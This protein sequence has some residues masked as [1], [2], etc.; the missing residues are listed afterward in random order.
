MYN[1]DQKARIFLSS[2]YNLG[3]VTHM[4][5]AHPFLCTDRILQ[6]LGFWETRYLVAGKKINGGI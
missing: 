2:V 6:R 4:T 3:I 1:A 5:Q